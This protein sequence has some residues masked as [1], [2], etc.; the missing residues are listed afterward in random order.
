MDV[1]VDA[2]SGLIDEVMDRGEAQKKVISLKKDRKSVRTIC[3]GALLPG[4]TDAHMHPLFYSILKALNPYSL[5]GFDR[6]GILGIFEK[7]K[8]EN[9]LPSVPLLF[10]EFDSSTVQQL[11]AKE[12]D[13]IFG[14]RQVAVYDASLHGGTVS[15][16][17]RKQI[18]KKTKSQ[19]LPGYLKTNGAFAEAYGFEVLSIMSGSNEKRLAETIEKSILHSLSTGVTTLHDLLAFNL[20]SFKTFLKVRKNWRKKHGYDFPVSR[21]YLRLQTLKKLFKNWATW[22]KRGLVSDVDLLKHF[23]IKLFA[24]GSLGARTANLTHDYDDCPTCGLVF[25]K[26]EDF[27]E[28]YIF[29]DETIDSKSMALHAIGDMGINR[30]LNF[31]QQV[32]EHPSLTPLENFFRI[33]HFELPSAEMI[34][35]ARKFGVHVVPQPN[36]LLDIKYADR[37]R[38]RIND[39]CPLQ[40]ISESEVPMMF[41]TDGMPESMLYAIYL[42]THARRHSQKITF[43]QA[44]HYSSESSAI[45]EKDNRGKIGAGQ[46]ADL[47]LTDLSLLDDLKEGKPDVPFSSEA[48][49]PKVDFLHSKI[50]QVYK[51]GKL[52]FERP[53]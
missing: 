22:K 36:F 33:E 41:G 24:D 43:E 14:Q 52:V 51:T 17:L 28:A 44:M 32:N 11:E 25:D 13:E 47:L 37:L 4:L 18:E 5:S 50:R 39:I 7:A 12:L 2:K 34:A 27:M 15:S 48:V 53:D 6:E 38:D 26:D 23:G 40:E 21:F 1:I 10:M 20:E 19:T 42:A 31:I 46:K 30:V 35:T 49:Q 29:S 3:G 8:E 16:S 45:F 9:P